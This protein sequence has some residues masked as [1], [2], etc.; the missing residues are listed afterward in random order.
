MRE[1][2]ETGVVQFGDDYPGVFIRGDNCFHFATQIGLVLGGFAERHGTDSI[3]YMLAK[4]A[5]GNLR[6]LLLSADVHAPEPAE[7]VRIAEWSRITTEA[8]RG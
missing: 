1:R 7:P 2:I 4:A 8:G 6:T 5:L 3:E